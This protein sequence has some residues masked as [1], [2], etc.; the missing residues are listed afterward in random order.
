MLLGRGLGFCG[1]AL[2]SDRWHRVLRL[3]GAAGWGG[4][5]TVQEPASGGHP[6]GSFFLG[7]V[8][9]KNWACRLGPA[10]CRGRNVTTSRG[11]G[12]WA[13]RL[14]AKIIGHGM[15]GDLRDVLGGGHRY[16]IF[17]TALDF[18]LLH[19]QASDPGI[20]AF[21][22][23]RIQQLL[24]LLSGVRGKVQMGQLARLQGVTGRRQKK[25]PR[26]LGWIMTSQGALQ[27]S[28][29]TLPVV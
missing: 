11:F 25:I 14:P 7:C 21:L 2:C 24:D 20:G 12:P 27:L 29:T 4:A 22:D 6:T 8:H 15:R 28:E 17:S 18:S 5:S 13:S 19:Q 10:S 3:A 16:S 1:D 23:I 26:R 9:R